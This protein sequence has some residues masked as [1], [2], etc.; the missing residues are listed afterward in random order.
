MM[1]V[2][3]L[4]KAPSYKTIYF[5]EFNIHKD[6]MNFLHGQRNDMNGQKEENE[7]EH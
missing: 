7:F 3:E 5:K 1:C 6:A 4:P 2:L